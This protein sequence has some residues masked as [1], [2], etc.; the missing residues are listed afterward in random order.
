[1]NVDH[2]FT[3]TLLTAQQVAENLQVP[4]S[5]VHRA[6]RAGQLAAVLIG[7]EYRYTVPDVAAYIEQ[8]RSVS[9]PVERRAHS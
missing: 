5:A 3:I 6:R 1:M 4:V 2:G 8:R 7:R 9:A